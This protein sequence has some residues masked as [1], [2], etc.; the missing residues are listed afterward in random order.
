MPTSKCKSI[1]GIHLNLL[2][3]FPRDR[4]RG[5]ATLNYFIVKLAKPSDFSAE[6]FS[7]HGR[8]CMKAPPVD[9]ATFTQYI[10]TPELVTAF[11]LRIFMSV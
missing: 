9:P 4:A 6:K 8:A 1:P 7:P 11:L 5:S 10:M 3:M 2:S